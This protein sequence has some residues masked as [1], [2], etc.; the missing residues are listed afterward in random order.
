MPWSTRD[1]IHR[2]Q[3]DANVPCRLKLPGLFG[4]VPFQVESVD[5]VHDWEF[6]TTVAT[7]AFLDLA[8]GI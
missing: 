2:G 7:H 4:G 5:P 1:E 8:Y 6:P 3:R